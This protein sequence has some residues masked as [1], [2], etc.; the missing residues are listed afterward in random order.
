MKLASTQMLDSHHYGVLCVGSH[1]SHFL[2]IGEFMTEFQG[3]A[4][5]LAKWP[6]VLTCPAC[7]TEHSYWEPDFVCSGDPYTYQPL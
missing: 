4:L 2:Y 6:L 5:K 7:G 1:C 3:A